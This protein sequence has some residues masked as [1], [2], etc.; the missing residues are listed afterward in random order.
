[1]NVSVF[2]LLANR[3]NV[4]LIK[5]QRLIPRANPSDLSSPTYHTVATL[6]LVIIPHAPQAARE[7]SLFL[8]S[9]KR[10]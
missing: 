10:A 4:T 7:K 3:K 8:I 2:G 6:S 9:S 5:R 1:M